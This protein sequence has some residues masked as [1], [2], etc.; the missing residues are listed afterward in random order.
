MGP[1]GRGLKGGFSTF[2][3]DDE[4]GKE[5]EEDD[6]ERKEGEEDDDDFSDWGI[7]RKILQ[8]GGF[9]KN[10]PSWGIS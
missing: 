3:D 6:E 2:E 10:P 8:V 9:L 4:E 1:K 5:G 7:F